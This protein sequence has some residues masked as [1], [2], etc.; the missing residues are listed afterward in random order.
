MFYVMDSYLKRWLFSSNAKDIGVMY[1]IFALFS[2]MIGT[3][4]SML[5]RME[6]SSPGDLYLGNNNSYQLYNVIITGHAFMMIF[7]MVMPGMLGGFGNIFLPIMIGAVDMS[8]PRLNNISLW[9]LVPSLIILLAS[10]FV[11][12]G[13]GTG[14]TVYPP[15]S[16][17]ESHSGGSVDL[18][19][20]SLHLAGISSLLGSINFITT[21]INMRAPGLSMHKLPLFVWA[22]FIT[23]ILLLLSLPVLAGAITMLLTDRNLNTTFYD[24]AGG[25]DSV[26]YEHLFWFFGQLDGPTLQQTVSGKLIYNNNTNIISLKLAYIVKNYN[27]KINNPQVTKTQMSMRLGTSENIRLLSE[28]LAGL[29]DGDGCFL[30]SKKGYASLEITMDIRDQL[31]LYKIKNKYGGSIKIRSGTNSVRY[32]LHHKLGLINCINDINGKIRLPNRMIQLINICKHYNIDFIYPKP[33]E[34]NNGW[35]S[36]LLDADG[37]V[38]INLRNLQLSISISQKNY[39][40]LEVIKNIYEGNIYID[41][42]TNTFKWYITKEQDIENLLK[43][44]KENPC[45]SEKKKRLHLIPRWYKIKELKH[46]PN[47]E[48]CLHYFL[49]KWNYYDK[50]MFHK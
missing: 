14:W 37:T 42:N 29:I 25:G 34:Y 9:L 13:A 17:I 27:L 38:T 6:L 20:F 35:L 18:A 33:L 44:L 43:Y 3:A 21:V 5:I 46:L 30:L 47:Y 15:L 12:Q 26:L 23:A 50:D 32:R 28:W 11:E 19:I 16:S 45:Y 22:V 48:K 2:G 39:Q 49:N 40:L 24:A 10:I 4:L 7:F 36:G 1:I 8:F 31:C 41:R